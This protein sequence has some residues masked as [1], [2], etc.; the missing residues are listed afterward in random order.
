M[1]ELK[2]L[3]ALALSL[4]H[5]PG[6]MALLVGS[7][8]SRA[9]GVPTGWDITLDLVRRLG[10]L[11]GVDGEDDWAAWYHQR[12]G[13]TPDYSELLDALASTTGERRNLL[14]SYIEAK[15]GEGGRRPTRA[16]HAIAR[17]VADGAVRVILTTNFDR[18]LESALRDA[19]V[20][21][22][23]VAHEDALAGATPL[24]HSRCTVL[25]LHGDYLDERIRNTAA[26]LA[27]YAPAMDRL[28]DEVFD[29]YGLLVAGWSGEWDE[30]LRRAIER[31]PTRRYPFYWATRGPLGG[32]AE[33]L[34]THRQGRVIAIADADAFFGELAETLSALREADR[35]HPLSLAA[36]MA[37]GRRYCRDDRFSWSGRSCSPNRPHGFAVLSPRPNTAI[38]GAT[39]RD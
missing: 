3:E 25:K 29:R 17:L 10:A 5:S 18:L 9:A 27:A 15:P 8:L 39:S 38:S 24:V 4:H 30:A 11:K 35:P 22:T 6:V 37:V 16:H 7:G 2:P 12:F 13:T 23:V 26:E 32:R 21:P 1:L 14:Q 19:G 31:C 28:L 34:V 33:D 20:E 36:T